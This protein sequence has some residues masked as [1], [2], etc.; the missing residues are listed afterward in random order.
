MARAF[1]KRW[2]PTSDS[3]KSNPGLRY[4]SHYLQ[5][6]NL[7]HLNRRSVSL[8]FFWGMFV[9]F[10][11]IP[12]QMP[13]AALAALWAR[14]NLPITV[15]LV[16]I[17]NPFTTPIFLFIVFHIGCFVLQTDYVFLT[18]ELSVEW[19]AH[20]LTRVW[21]PLL[22]GSVLGGVGVGALCYAGV[23][24]LWRLHAIFLWNKRKARRASR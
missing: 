13:V 10:L 12:G 18:P 9:A 6:P 19:L 24:I 14:S 3:I 16:W 4:F 8:A 21:K 7:F 17:T 22:V 20:S 23:R 15:A 1:F 11:P 2:I 5:D